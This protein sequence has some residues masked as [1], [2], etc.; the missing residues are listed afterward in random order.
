MIGLCWGW[1]CRVGLSMNMGTYEHLH[2]YLWRS[3]NS[4]VP[5]PLPCVR[6][7]PLLCCCAH[8]A[9]WPASFWGLSPPPTLLKE[10]TDKC[11]ESG[12]MWV[13]KTFPTEPSP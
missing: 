10:T 4:L 13:L 9:S 8:Q 2:E 3:E 5:Y 11:W 6:R 7:G 12:C 1:V